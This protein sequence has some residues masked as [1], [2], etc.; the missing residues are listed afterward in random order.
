[1]SVDAGRS[2]RIGTRNALSARG[3]S[4]C[5]SFA[6]MRS[7]YEWSFYSFYYPCA[8]QGSCALQGEKS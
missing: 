8:I 3:V 2:N 1:M 7:A 4:S 6:E 5:L